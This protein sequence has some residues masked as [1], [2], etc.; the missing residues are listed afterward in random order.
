MKSKHAYWLCQILGWGSYSLVGGLSALQAAN[1]PT[2][3]AVGYSLYFL[4]SIALTHGLRAF[5]RRR[6]WLE[7]DHPRYVPSFLA[8]WAVGWLQ[9]ALVV[10][11]D[12]LLSHGRSGFLRPSPMWGVICSISLVPLGW[13]ML[14]I[15]I[16]TAR[17][18]KEKLLALRDAELRALELQINPHFLFNS[19]NSIRALVTENPPLAQDLLTRLANI[20]RYNLHR[21]AG[22]TVP[23]SSELEAAADYLALE[24]AR[25]EDRL[26][27]HTTIAPETCRLPVPPMLVQTL[28]ENAIKHGIAAIPEG[29]DLRLS[30][31]VENGALILRVENPGQVGQAPRVVGPLRIPPANGREAAGLGLQNLRD[32][33]RI[34][35]GPRAKLDLTATN[36]HVTA[37][38][39]I[40]AKP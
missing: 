2:K 35:Y 29:G 11:I 3:V 21:D 22:H 9:A 13:M 25:Y 1:R 27:I 4:Y 14:Y 34:L 33:L 6:C 20:L 30:T 32:R 39:R 15:A 23:L 12:S 18:A 38:V 28:V 16:T 19:L 24:S 17:R 8:A 26:R 7:S 36:G 31:A 37:T 10:G 40:P 5:V